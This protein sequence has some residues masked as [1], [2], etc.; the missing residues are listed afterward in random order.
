MM[1]GFQ[2]VYEGF[3][4]IPSILKRLFPPPPGNTLETLAYLIANLKVNRFL[5]ANEN[6]WATIS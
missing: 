2:Y 6:A 3:Y 4:S 1:S 5:K